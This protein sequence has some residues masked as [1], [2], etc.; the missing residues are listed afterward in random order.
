MHFMILMELTFPPLLC[1][2]VGVMAGAR[3]G[4]LHPGPSGPR[5]I[6]A[7]GPGLPTPAFT[8]AQ[9]YKGKEI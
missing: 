1:Y 4:L 8:A 7:I 3:R 5:G 9:G 6:L 2:S